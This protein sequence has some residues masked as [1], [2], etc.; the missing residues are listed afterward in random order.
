MKEKQVE[1]IAL[2]ASPYAVPFYHAIGFKDLDGQQDF[3]RILYTPM[4]FML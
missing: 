3:H 4:K 1:K 2:N